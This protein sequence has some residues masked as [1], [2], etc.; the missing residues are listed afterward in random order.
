[1]LY[2]SVWAI[3]IIVYVNDNWEVMNWGLIT[4]YTHL[5]TYKGVMQRKKPLSIHLSYQRHMFCAFFV[6]FICL[7]FSP[8]LFGFIYLHI[9][10][11]VVDVLVGFRNEAERTLMFTHHVTHHEVI[12]SVLFLLW[13]WFL[14]WS[15]LNSK[16]GIPLPT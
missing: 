8:V 3:H 15:E 1:M 14:I 2:N 12:T 10:N 5:P 13:I 4:C 11:F 6:F 7:F 16:N 9:L